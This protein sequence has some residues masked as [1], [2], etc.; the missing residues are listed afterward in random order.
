VN[1]HPVPGGVV[2]DL[3]PSEFVNR[4]TSDGLMVRIGPF[5]AHIRTSVRELTEP[6]MRLYADYPLLTKDEIFSFRVELNRA[7]NFPH[8]YRSMVR[9]SV[10]GRLLHED[11]PTSQALAVLEWGIN[12]VIAMRAHHFLILHSA[13]LERNGIGLLL[14]A[15]PGFGKSTLC[16]ALAHRGWRLLSDEF[17]LVRP[18]S[19]RIE[20][21]PRPIA[22]KNESIDVLRAFAPD[23]VIGPSIVGTRKGTVAH[24]KA[25]SSSVEMQAKMAAAK[26]VVFPRWQDG[27]SLE[28]DSLSKSDGF[29]MVAMNAFNYELLGEAGFNTVAKIIGASDCY[30]LKYS[31]LDEAISAI[32]ALADGM[33]NGEN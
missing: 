3:T 21:V 12:L 18:G 24:V 29:M 28:I 27:A 22:L 10:E 4:A 16:A 5:N 32:D 14:P 11:M 23:A 15:A 20:S 9:F 26:L 17:G 1:S 19:S 30:R 33:I 31:D 6:L 25:P 2:A 7:R 8:F 13:V